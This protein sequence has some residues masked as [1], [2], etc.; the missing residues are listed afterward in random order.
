MATL[1]GLPPVLGIFTSILTSPV[2]AILGRNPMLIGGTGS[3]T[4]PFIAEAVRRQG[5][6]GAAKV[7]IVAAVIMMAFCVLRLGRHISRV[8]HAVVTGFSCGI[9]AI[10]IVSQLD[11]MLGLPTGH[12]ASNTIGQLGAILDHLG[13]F[14]VA[15]FVTGLVVILA[16][17]ACTTW[18]PR[19][20]A[21][22]VGITV[23][24]LVAKVLSFHVSEIGTLPSGLPPFVGFAWSPQDVYAVLPAAFGLAFVT[25]V[26]VLITSRVVEHFRGRHR[27]HSMSDA[28]AE[29]GAY[30]IANVCAGTFGAPLSVGIPARSLAAVRCGGTT[31]LSN[32]F[33]ALILILMLRYAGGL[34][35]HIPLAAMAGVTAWMGFCLLDWSAWR[36]LSKMTHADALGFLVTAGAVVLVNAVLAVAIGCLV[37]WAPALYRRWSGTSEQIPN[38]QIP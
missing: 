18:L 10:M 9:G 32:I 5:I 36:R 24:V 11:I 26:N 16:A 1:M 15:P 34:I 28:D 27:R 37:Y 20:P 35:S 31:R 8:P 38:L 17:T 6:A 25:S 21:P 2:T 14:S 12:A 4:V 3:A 23:A 13:S 19:I 7:S 30:G 33:H 22:L 29:L